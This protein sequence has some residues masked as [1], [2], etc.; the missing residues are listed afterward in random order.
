MEK[1]KT[2]KTNYL[3]KL[4]IDKEWDSVRLPIKEHFDKI[5]EQKDKV[6]KRVIKTCSARSWY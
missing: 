5:S 3:L 2:A 6:K 4:L 1:E